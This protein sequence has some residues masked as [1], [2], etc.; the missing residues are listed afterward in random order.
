MSGA[1]AAV[2]EFAPTAALTVSGALRLPSLRRGDP[3]VLAGHDQLERPLRWAHSSD[4]PNVADLLSGGELLLVTG[5][6]VGEGAVEQRRYVRALAERELAGLVVEL[7]GVFRAMPSAMVREA[8]ACGLPLVALRREVPFV[9]VTE[10]IHSALV[11][12]QLAALRRADEMHRR[13]TALMLDGAGVAEILAALSEAIANPVLLEKAGQGVL[14]HAIHRTGAAAVLATWQTAQHDPAAAGGATVSIP[15]AG[16]RAWGRIVALPV[17]SGL[18]D[19][20]LATI[21]RAAA[22]IALALLRNRQELLLSTRQRGNFLADVAAGRESPAD[23]PTRAAHLGFTHARGPLLPVAIVT[24]GDDGEGEWTPVWRALQDALTSQ[25]LP[26]LIGARRDADTL[27][28]AGLRGE[29]PAERARVADLLADALRRAYLRH[30]GRA[31][32][33]VLAVGPAVS[34]WGELPRALR[35]AEQ[36]ARAAVHAPQRPW[37]DATEADVD[38]LLWSL[39]DDP[40]LS[41]LMARRLEP[42][43]EHDRA[44]AAKLMPTLVALCDHGWRR[45]DTARALHLN[46]QSL[47]PRLRR[48]EQL[49]GVDLDDTKGRLE[50]ELAVRLWRQTGGAPERG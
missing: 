7:G 49:V 50:L 37:H 42:V 14:Y 4:V 46:R 23:A 16:D 20:D 44:R 13:F 41:D 28:L 35:D 22:L 26:V 29:D 25:G 21:E 18:D 3:V 30:L 15:A 10:E 36:T 47:Y 17:D 19:V 32:A 9:A 11:G 1:A 5:M 40:R 45:V 12:R 43:L 24:T 33:A 27:V 39:R 2:L 34:G 6:G 31:R 8:E 38:R 48:L